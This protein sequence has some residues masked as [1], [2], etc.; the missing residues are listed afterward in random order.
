[1]AKHRPKRGPVVDADTIVPA[2]QPPKF[3]VPKVVTGSLVE[4]SATGTFDDFPQLLNVSK[5]Q[6][7]CINVAAFGQHVA[8]E[9]R[10]TDDPVLVEH[11][12][13]RQTNGAWREAPF[14]R[15]ISELETQVEVLTA[16]VAH[17]ETLN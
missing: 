13:Q 3:C 5:V 9:V 8:S 11:P 10:H 17:L 7:E 15:K 14:E 6:G 1:M 2:S 16:K 4:Y 12:R